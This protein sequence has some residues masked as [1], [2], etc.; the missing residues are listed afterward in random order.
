MSMYEETFEC[1]YYDFNHEYLTIFDEVLH[2]KPIGDKERIVDTIIRAIDNMEYLNLRVDV[3]KFHENSST[4]ECDL[5]SQFIVGYDSDSELIYFLDLEDVKWS[6]ST[7]GFKEFERAFAHGTKLIRTGIVDD[8]AL[9]NH[10]AL[11]EPAYTFSLRP[12]TPR[13]IRLEVILFELEEFLKGGI[14]YSG[15]NVVKRVGTSIYNAYYEGLYTRFSLNSELFEDERAMHLIR[16]GLRR[17]REN[18]IGLE[19]RLKYLDS[20]KI[21]MFDVNIFSQLQE[22]SNLLSMASVLVG[23]FLYTHDFRSLEKAS[24]YFMSAENLDKKILSQ[25]SELVFSAIKKSI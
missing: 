21:V 14:L 23:K 1:V 3:N 2:F 4:N 5:N 9:K 11:N 20:N 19:Y 6:I 13:T 24:N 10:L 18:K 25:T 12:I 22:L 16:V 7:V 15:R 8:L 17:L